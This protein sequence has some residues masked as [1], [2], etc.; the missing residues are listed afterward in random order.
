ML[1]ELY[2]ISYIIRH[3]TVTERIAL[4]GHFQPSMYRKGLFLCFFVCSDSTTSLRPNHCRVMEDENPENSVSMG[5]TQ[6]KETG[7]VFTGEGTLLKDTKTHFVWIS[8]IYVSTWHK[9]QD[10]TGDIS[11]LPGLWV[12]WS[13]MFVRTFE[14]YSNDTLYFS[15]LYAMF[16]HVTFSLSGF[17]WG[18]TI[19]SPEV[20]IAT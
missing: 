5:C 6:T 1:P 17:L 16:L 18:W 10:K 9:A 11:I 12:L 3:K 15:Y 19:R 20:S 7:S 14:I 2:L 4:K 8:G 13:V